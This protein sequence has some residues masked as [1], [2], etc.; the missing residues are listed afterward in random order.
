MY[1]KTITSLSNRAI[2]DA[3][4]IKNNRNKYKHRAFLVE[5]PHLVEMALESRFGISE[6][7]GTFKIF[8][9][10]RFSGRQQ[11]KR[12]IRK[13]SEKNHELIE[14][15]EKILDKLC[16]T[17]A[18]QGIVAVLSYASLSLYDLRLKKKPFL[19][20]IDGIRDPGNLGTIIRTADAAG[21]DGVI[22]LP[23]TCDTFMPKAIRA[24]A[25]SLFNMPVINSETEPF[26]TWLRQKKIRL[27]VTS[28]EAS[29]SLFSSD[30]SIPLAIAFGNEAYG[31]SNNMRKAADLSLRIPIFGA[32]ESLNVAVSAAVFL[33][34]AARQRIT[35]KLSD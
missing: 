31:I 7:S 3:L 12:L 23:G 27:V 5:G 19:V 21:I 14:V 2:K 18:P 15:T 9:T 13:L 35:D 26:I 32:A 28:P 8:F 33:Y 11:G 16:D 1:H 22:C 30:L 29:E 4:Q 10:R 24:T 34:E 6:N 25:G 17:E 20:V